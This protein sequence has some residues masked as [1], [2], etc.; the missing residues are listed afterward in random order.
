M[1]TYSDGAPFAHGANFKK[2]LAPFIGKPEISGLEVGS[3]EGRSALWLMENILTHE[4][5]GMYCID[6]WKGEEVQQ[7]Q[8]IDFSM[9]EKNF[10]ENTAEYRK[11]YRIYV[12]KVLSHEALAMIYPCNFHF[13][14]IDGSHIAPDVL[15]DAVLVWRLLK[16]DGVAIFDDYAWTEGKGLR[17]RPKIAIDA[18]LDVFQEQIEILDIGYQVAVRR[19]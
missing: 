9:K 19:K 15:M 10:L 17:H 1:P 5:S 2:W 3:W 13:A 14:Y 18:F 12:W 16:K 8:G 6:T 4:K 11:S 7:Q